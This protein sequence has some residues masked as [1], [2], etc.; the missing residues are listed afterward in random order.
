MGLHGSLLSV[1]VIT[2]IQAKSR[3]IDHREIR[4]NALGES[5]HLPLYYL[6]A[7]TNKG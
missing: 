7:G 2:G 3:S 5:I 4:P 6:L 1:D